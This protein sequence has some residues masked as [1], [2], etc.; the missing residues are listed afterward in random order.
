MSAI[1]TI[2]SIPKLKSFSFGIVD[3][4]VWHWRWAKTEMARH[5][6]DALDGLATGWLVWQVVGG[7]AGTHLIFNNINKIFQ[8]YFFLA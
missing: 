8:L 2:A 3:L 6:A 5:L 4:T 1:T 7:F